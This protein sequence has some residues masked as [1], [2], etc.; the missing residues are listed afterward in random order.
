MLNDAV[1]RHIELYRSMGF[2]YKVQEYILHSF[3]VFAESRSEQFIRAD[4]VLEWAAKAPT[5]RRRYDRLFI[6][7]RLAC[8]LNAEDDRHQ[9][10][11]DD[12][13][14]RAPKSRRTC[15]IFTEDEI[16]RLLRAAAQLSSRRSIAP[17]TFIALLCLITATGLRVSEALKLQL[18]DVTEDGLLIRATKFHKDRLVP[19]HESAQRG[20][21]QYLTTRKRINTVS[22]NVFVSKY[23]AALPY[24]TLYATFL[25]LARLAGLRLGPGH[26]GCRVHD[27]RHTFAVRSLEQCAGDR[28]AVA[29]HI[30]ALS[31]YLGHTHVSDT[32]WYLQGTPRLLG[33]VACAAEAL[34]RGGER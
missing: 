26:R 20:L 12:A 10:P 1:K 25:Y 3:A 24:S 27:A 29:R 21:Q 9:V 2:K 32:Y 28:K 14:G 22:L 5:I 23:G 15:H 33:D 31:T 13:F 16:Q 8:A 19:L 17:A 6:V 30:S 34:Y 18:S 7:R 4:T 11:P